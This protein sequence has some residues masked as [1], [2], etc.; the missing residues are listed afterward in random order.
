M[1]FS[2]KRVMIVAAEAALLITGR[3]MASE[4]VVNGPHNLNV[5]AGL[6]LPQGQ[7]CIA[8]HTP[9]NVPNNVGGTYQYLWNHS[10]NLTKV[11]TLYGN[12]SGSTL[13]TASRL[14]LSCHDGGANVDAFG[15]SAGTVTI[16]TL[17]QTDINGNPVVGGS[18]IGTSTGSGGNATGSLANSH[19]VGVQYGTSTFASTTGGNVTYS[20]NYVNS[21]AQFN[22]NFSGNGTQGKVRLQL[23]GDGTTKAVVSCVTCHT[24]HD[25]TNGFFLTIRNDNSQLCLQC[26]N[27]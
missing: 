1:R 4:S 19:P 2:K 15:S 9:H 26:H 7:V 22:G 20:G 12:A 17:T 18:Q 13:D 6:S 8:C 27:E 25:D 23:A 14:C 3:A 5:S 16:S 10:I 21:L 11:Y 24:P